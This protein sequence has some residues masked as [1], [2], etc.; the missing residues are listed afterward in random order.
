MIS[1]QWTREEGIAC[2][3]PY[4]AAKIQ[5]EEL[6]ADLCGLFQRAFHKRQ[7]ALSLFA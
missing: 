7:A 5:I 2:V 4:S 3:L 6:A 1:F